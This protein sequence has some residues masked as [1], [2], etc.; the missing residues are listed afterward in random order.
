MD[1]YKIEIES[2]E[3]PE[4]QMEQVAGGEGGLTLPDLNDNKP[5]SGHVAFG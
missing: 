1:E 3:L 2:D 5:D 4:E